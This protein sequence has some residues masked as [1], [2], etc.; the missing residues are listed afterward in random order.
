MHKKKK[1]RTARAQLGF[2]D[3]LEAHIKARLVSVTPNDLG[4]A[5]AENYEKR[6]TTHRQ[7]LT[8]LFPRNR[9]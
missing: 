8:N 5:N 9:R 7:Q 3:K 6:D 2:D 4:N 1:I